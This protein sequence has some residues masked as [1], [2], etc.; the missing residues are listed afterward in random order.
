MCATAAML[1][2]IFIYITEN[3]NHAIVLQ[4][5]C[6][7]LLILKYVQI[8]CWANSVLLVLDY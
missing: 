5:L 2:E 3:I 8:S 1:L 4:K 7:S 6:F